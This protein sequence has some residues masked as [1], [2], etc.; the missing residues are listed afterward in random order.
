MHLIVVE[1][2]HSLSQNESFKADN[3]FTWQCCIQLKTLRIQL[4][5]LPQRISF[6]IV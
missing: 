5:D 3:D 1:A 2:S 6:L 4:E